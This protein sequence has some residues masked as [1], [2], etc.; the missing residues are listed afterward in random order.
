[1]LIKL[2][3]TLVFEKKFT[4][5]NLYTLPFKIYKLILGEKLKILT[6]SVKKG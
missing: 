4:L 5:M 2:G 3:E 1:M 6:C